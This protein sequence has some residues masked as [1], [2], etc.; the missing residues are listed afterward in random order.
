MSWMIG[1]RGY[2][3]LNA[4]M[5]PVSARGWAMYGLQLAADEEHDLLLS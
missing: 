1:S 4:S 5:C 3:D 2:L